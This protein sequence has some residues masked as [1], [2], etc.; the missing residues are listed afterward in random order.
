MTMM[1]TDVCS[2]IF[3]LIGDVYRFSMSDLG[4]LQMAMSGSA[5]VLDGSSFRVHLP[6]RQNV[7]NALAV[8]ACARAVGVSDEIIAD[9]LESVQ[10]VPGRMELVS[11]DEFDA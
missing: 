5:F 11:H 10:T 2:A 6:G 3:P 1:S 7:E 9:G 4:N 8:I